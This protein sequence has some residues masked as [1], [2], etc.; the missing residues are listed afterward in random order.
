MGSSITL[1]VGA[2]TGIDVAADTI[3]VDLSELTT[4]TSDGDGDYFVV[5]NTSNVQRK[6]TKG[7][8]NLS[9][10]N[11]NISLYKADG[12]LSAART[13][14]QNGNNLEFRTTGAANTKFRKTTQANRSLTRVMIEADETYDNVLELDSSDP[15]TFLVSGYEAGGARVF[16]VDGQGNLMATSKAFD[17]PHPNPEKK[18]QGMRLKHGN[19][20]GPEH[21][22][23]IRGRQLNDKEIE[24]PEYWKDLVDPDSITVQL[25]SVGSHQ[26]LYVKEIKDW[27]V[28][29]QNGNLFSNK[30]DCYYFIQAERID[31]D[32]IQV[33]YIQ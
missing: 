2:G 30:I 3:S 11:D 20:E 1:N 24:L 23:Y 31:V 12:T 13:V 22:I 21:G 5:V 15:N 17:I 33:E 19:L 6:L 10:F 32:K 7:N 27:V 16:S 9:G 26:N 18:E 4:S 29:I 25:T 14:T 8:I 28:Y